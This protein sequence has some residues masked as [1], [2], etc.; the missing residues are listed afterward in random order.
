MQSRSSNNINNHFFDGVY[1][2]VWKKLIPAGLTEAEADFIQEIGELKE[3]DHALDIMCGYGRH[4]LELGRRGIKVTGIDNAA[5]YTEEINR[6]VS[7]EN[8]DVKAFCDNVIDAELKDE[9]DIAICMGNSFAFFDEAQSISLLKKIAA[10]LKPGGK[11][12]INTW[13][14][15]EIAIRHFKEKDWYYVDNYKNLLD[16]SYHFN[17]SRIETEHTII[18]ENGN[19]SSIKGVD[20][21]F[22]IA[23]LQK[24]FLQCGFT[25][26]NI[27]S[28]PRKR[29][30]SLGD[31]RAYIVADKK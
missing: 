18:D 23:E 13:M 16:N 4:A 15:A 22:T 31:G 27:Y 21:I 29:K 10:H 3:G 25:L 28:T 17:P 26:N 9:F 2:D 8:I 11:F 1:K 30:F 7:K 20:Y 19:A 12:I 14:I 6:Q 24:M 5:D